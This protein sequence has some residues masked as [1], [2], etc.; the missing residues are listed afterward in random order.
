[1]V[2]ER[3]V[4]ANTNDIYSFNN[5]LKEGLKKGRREGAINELE[6]IRGFILFEKEKANWEDNLRFVNKRLKL[7]GGEK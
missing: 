4:L 2:K 7:Q 5:G 1:M 3:I 6:I